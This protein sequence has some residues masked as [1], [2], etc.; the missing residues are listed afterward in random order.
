MTEA[1]G[2][3]VRRLRLVGIDRSYEVDFTSN[4]QVR[5][6]SV[7]SGAF[8]SG[9]TAVLEFVAYGLGAKR[10]P[11]HP[12]VLRKVRSAL[13]EVELSGAP[14]VIERAVGE[15]STVAF[16]R[17]GRLDEASASVPERRP[18]EPAGA[19]DSLSTL[20]LSHCKLEGVQLREAPTKAESRTDPLSFRDLMWLT[21]L[22]NERVADKN[23]LFENSPP[24]KHKLRQ[25]V[26]VVF[27]VHDDRAVELGARIK[28]LGERLNRSRAELAAA[29]TFVEEQQTG[30]A[31]DPQT[32]ATAERELSA[33]NTQLEELDQR[34]R[35]ATDFADQLRHTHRAAAQTA[36]QAAAVLRDR[37]TQLARMLPL[38]AQYAD[39]LVKL[40]MLAQARQ[41]FDPLRVRA[42]PACM[43]DLAE[44][45]RVVEGRC[46]MCRHELPPAPD[47]T[48]G[49]AIERHQEEGSA[50][51]DVGAEVRATKARLKEITAYIEELD[52]SLAEAREAADAAA[53][54]EQRAA[55]ALD[56]ATAPTVSTFLTARDELH[57]RKETATRLMD[58]LNA[59]AKLQ[60]GITKRAALVARQE[61][62]LSGLREELD[63]LGDAAQ[64]RADIIREISKRFARLL[65]EWHYPKLS[66]PHVATDLTPFV[67]GE[68]YQV[69]SSGA[70]TLITLAWQ[71]ALFET[72]Y[73]KTASHP[74]FLMIDSPQKNLGHDSGR[75]SVIAD[76]VSIDDFYRH[77]TQ[78]LA[79]HGNGAQVIVV[80]N[81]PPVL[82]EDQVIVR[83][84]RD[85]TQPPYGLIED[86]IG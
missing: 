13:L 19:P 69:A 22:P 55:K 26:D 43:H 2:I 28:Q 31:A 9:K 64:D 57:R 15:P 66:Q 73:E 32:R 56:E 10:H 29:K 61:A 8:S 3:R 46:S 39:D 51:L 84:S 58:Q 77:L 45:P 60:D 54:E 12:E 81:S 17:R 85:E 21:F 80:D 6:L 75:D 49:T 72:A 63:Q 42:C 7:I 52:A 41:L 76:A 48:L 82:I 70:R 36:R 23:F 59:S 86:E 16:V 38:R 5:G 30:T 34:A 24:R 20:L 65:S 35:A 50:Q 33:I 71:L 79:D 25:V 11:R 62:N 27:G 40:G 4:G 67:R 37:E 74:G 1:H 14:H 68:P 78:W 53:Q 47:L 44:L 18:L 83:Y